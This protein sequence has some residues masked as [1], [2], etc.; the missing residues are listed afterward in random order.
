MLTAGTLSVRNGKLTQVIMAS[1]HYHPDLCA[2][3]RLVEAL[4]HAGAGMDTVE[5][6][7]QKVFG[8]KYTL[9]AIGQLDCNSSAPKS[10]FKDG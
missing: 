4:Q 7:E 10:V 9:A 2:L 1:G 5:I 3:Q 6:R 8:K